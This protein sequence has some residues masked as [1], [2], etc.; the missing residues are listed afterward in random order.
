VEVVIQSN[1]STVS[2]L[3]SDVS[4]LTETEQC[5]STTTDN[6]T[7]DPAAQDIVIE[8]EDIVPK[9]DSNDNVDNEEATPNNNFCFTNDD[10]I[11]YRTQVNDSTRHQGDDRKAWNTIKCLKGH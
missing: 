1:P 8:N 2:N 9:D 7:L 5:Q 4:Q 3:V 10:F 6:N 11:E